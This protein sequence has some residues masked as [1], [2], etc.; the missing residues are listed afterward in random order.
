MYFNA[1]LFES[2]HLSIMQSLGESNVVVV[3]MYSRELLVGQCPWF[4]HQALT[5]GLRSQC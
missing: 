4:P 5:S 3:D 2:V 1:V